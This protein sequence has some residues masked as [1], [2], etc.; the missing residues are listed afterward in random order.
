MRNVTTHVNSAHDT[1]FDAVIITV[2]TVM[3]L[4]ICS[5]NILVIAAVTRTRRLQTVSNVF[6]VGLAIA[7]CVTGG[8]A[9]PVYVTTILVRHWIR[10]SEILANLFIFA[11]VCHIV[12]IGCS[13]SFMCLIAIE[14]YTAIFY[15]YIHLKHYTVKRAILLGVSSVVNCVLFQTFMF[16]NVRRIDSPL[17][18]SVD[19]T[20]I[21]LNS[22]AFAILFVIT[23][24]LHIRI[25]L[26]AQK[27][28]RQIAAMDV[29]YNNNE[30]AKRMQNE[31]KIAK[32]LATVLGCYYICWIPFVINELALSFY[33]ESRIFYIHTEG[34]PSWFCLIYLIGIALLFVNSMINPLIYAGMNKDFKIAFRDMLMCYQAKLKEDRR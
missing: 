29:T 32:M 13:I 4:A 22:S 2:Y 33:Y 5:G 20:H 10:S 28:K 34:I 17:I 14:R 25:A 24:V 19:K 27:H 1:E 12:C 21:C 6:V 15:P 31:R 26:L 3:S 11:N 7:D 18:I 8:L 30:A 9:I 23:N 16:M